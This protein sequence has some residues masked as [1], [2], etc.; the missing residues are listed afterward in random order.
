MEKNNNTDKA[1][2]LAVIPARGG[3]KSIK[4]KNI[5]K[6]NDRPLIEF[7]A[8]AAKKSKYIDKVIVSTDDIKIKKISERLNL[9]VPFKRPKFLSTDRANTHEVIKHAVNNYER[10]TND[11]FEIVITLQPTSPLRTSKHIDEAIKKFI[12]DKK[13]DSLISIQEVPHNFTPGSIMKL[14][15]KG[16]INNYKKNKIRLLRRQ[17]KPKFFARNGPAICITKRKKLEN[18]L[19]GGNVSYYIMDYFSS[20]DIDTQEDLE[21]LNKI[22]K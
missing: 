1:K 7:T 12:S 19:Y 15:T 18:Y 3:S 13:S 4:N 14:N 11:T 6:I 22:I 2:I 20:I 9:D 16:Y 17:D 5:I 8:N 21:L 10:I